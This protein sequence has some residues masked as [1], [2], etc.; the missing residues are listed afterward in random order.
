MDAV[1]DARPPVLFS[2]AEGARAAAPSVG[3]WVAVAALGALVIGGGAMGAL[4]LSRSLR[5]GARTTR[6]ASA[7]AETPRATASASAHGE[8]HI[9]STPAG[10]NVTVDGKDRGITPLKLT[11]LTVGTHQLALTSSAGNVRRSIKIVEG[12]PTEI[13]QAIFPGWVAVY[14]PFEVAATEGGRA[15]RIDEQDQI[16]LPP[17]VHDV[18]LANRTLNFTTVQHVEVNPGA[19][20]T[21]RVT[22]PTS[23]LTV[24]AAEP[25]EVWIDGSRIGTTPLVGVPAALGAHEILVRRPSGERRI[26]VTVRTEPLTVNADTAR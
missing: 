20:T 17:G 8:L 5:S 25:S 18:E 26:A 21:V 15:L 2:F 3:R 7:P 22:P 4:Y 9:T 12:K 13:D 11:D 6:P 24:T 10:A 23:T 1:E 14:A 16:M 19:I